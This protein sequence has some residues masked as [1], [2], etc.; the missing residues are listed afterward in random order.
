MSLPPTL[1]LGDDDERT[2]VDS[3]PPPT[4]PVARGSESRTRGTKK[5]WSSTLRGAW[6]PL[7]VGVCAVV[8][9]LSVVAFF[10]NQE[11]ILDR[12]S[13]VVERLQTEGQAPILRDQA[14]GPSP[15]EAQ[16]RVSAS[17]V[18]EVST[19][20]TS[21]R[22]ELELVAATTLIANDYHGALDRYQALSK[23]FPEEKVFSDLVSILRNKVGCPVGNGV[24]ESR[25][26]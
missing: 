3:R 13:Q 2:I 16:T 15:V 22:A 4:H 18:P 24:A 19:E 17:A 21:S 26:D 11:R 10:E 23:A 8:A 12:F 20:D 9:T 25:C 7:L 14:P 6:L 1:V 5:H